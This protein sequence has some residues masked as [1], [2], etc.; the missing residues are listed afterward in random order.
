MGRL[1][2]KMAIVT[3]SD[4][5]PGTALARGLA[6]EGATVIAVG[7]GPEPASGLIPGPD[8]DG[9]VS[10]QQRDVAR[11]SDWAGL[12][13]QVMKDH[14]GLDILINGPGEYQAGLLGETSAETFDALFARN[15]ESVFIGIQ[16]VMPAMAARGGGS[17]INIGSGLGIRGRA[18]TTAYCA[19]QGAV[20][21][22]TLAAALDGARR[23][24]RVNVIHAAALDGGASPLGQAAGDELTGAVVYLASN[25]ARLVTG[26]EMTLDGG[27]NAS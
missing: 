12:L 22:L 16:Q 21:Q 7:A 13:D 26:S 4:E 6:T 1:T 14:G 20:T 5:Q 8:A 19:T 27:A 2:G 18:G 24:I 23:K 10:Y 9:A 11:E 15:V 25:E 17:I 3:G